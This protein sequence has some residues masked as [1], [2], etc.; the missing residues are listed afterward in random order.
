MRGIK[1]V[2]VMDNLASEQKALHAEHGLSF[3]VETEEVRILFD[4]GAGSHA[5]ENAKKL[6]IRLDQVEYAL[7]SHG[8]YDHAGGYP[9]FV[10]AGLSCSLVTGKGFFDEKYALGAAKA[11]YL[12]NGFSREYL[13][14]KRIHHL[15]CE[16]VLSLA[17]HCWVVG[18][19]RRKWDFETIPERFVIR[20]RQ[21][22][23]QDLFEDEVCLV[24]EE[25][26]EL[27]VILGCSHPGVLNILEHVQEQFHKP[28]RVV[29]G[30]THLIEADRERIGKTLAVMKDLGIRILGFNHCSGTLLREMLQDYKEFTTVYLGSGDCLFL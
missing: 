6:G 13:E 3:Y 25:K 28:V 19:F 7:C 24:L 11:T 5:L 18:A 20:D 8:H 27:A 14:E 21:G 2:T 17:D 26:E 1:I 9:W 30:G 4:F 12:G 10:Q 16:N 22:F 15:E 29:V 23:R